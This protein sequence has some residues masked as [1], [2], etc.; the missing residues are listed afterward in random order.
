MRR[1]ITKLERKKTPAM[2]I[3]EMEYGIPIELLI[4]RG[5][6]RDVGISLGV[7]HAV[8][9]TWRKKLGVEKEL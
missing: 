3:I 9:A 1:R 6:V 7:S 2:K 8:I 4:S 5:S